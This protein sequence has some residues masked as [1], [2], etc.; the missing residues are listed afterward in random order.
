M[1]V[2]FFFHSSRTNGSLGICFLSHLLDLTWGG[3]KNSLCHVFC[4][5]DRFRE[6]ILR[7]NFNF[8]IIG[9]GSKLN[10]FPQSKIM[11]VSSY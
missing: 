2:V 10:L 5:P 6:L 4:H 8:I 11:S 7:G 1:N 9:S 3:K